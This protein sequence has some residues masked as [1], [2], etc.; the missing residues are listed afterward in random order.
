[1][2]TS[3]GGTVLSGRGEEGAYEQDSSTNDP[4]GHFE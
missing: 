2:I 4:L 1:M 3:A